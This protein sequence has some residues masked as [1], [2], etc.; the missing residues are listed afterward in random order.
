[1]RTKSICLALAIVL[2][3]PFA[4][5]QWVQTNSPDDRQVPQ[6]PLMGATV[7]QETPRELLGL[8]THHRMPADSLR[9]RRM[10]AT[11][12]EGMFI[13]NSIQ[14]S[15]PSLRRMAFSQSQIYVIDTAI[16]KSNAFSPD[17]TRHLYSFN[18]GAKKTSDFTQRLNGDIWVD[19]KRETYTY[20]A[21]NNMLTDIQEQSSSGQWVKTGYCYIYE[22][23]ANGN[24]LSDLTE[25]WSNNGLLN[26]SGYKFTY[27]ARGNRTFTL[28]EYRGNGQLIHSDRWTYTYDASRNKLSELW[29]HLPQGSSGFTY[30]TT[31]I[32]DTNGHPLSEMR[33]WW[34]NGQWV[35]DYRFT[36]TYDANGNM[37][38]WLGEGWLNGQWVNGWRD[39]YT[40][41]ANSHMLSSLSENW[42]GSQRMS[43]ER[44]TWT[45]DANGNMLSELLENWSNGQWVNN[46]LYTYTYDESGNM[47][48]SLQEGWSNNQWVGLYHFTY[49]YDTNGNRLSQLLETWSDGQWANQSLWTYAYDEETKLT[50]FWSYDWQNSAWT[51][52]TTPGPGGGSI[53]V[54]DNAGNKYIL[55]RCYNFTLSS[56][57]IVTGIASRSETT[58][59]SYALSQNY[60]NPFNPSTTI[61]FQ[62]PRASQV[63]LTVFD[64]VGRDVSV[65]VNDRRD[66][67]VH[68]V[69]FDASGL[70]SGVYF[71]RL[72]A[73]DFT[74][75]KRLLLLR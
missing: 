54:S 24:C 65:L 41:D 61:K 20:D 59:A 46:V 69:R 3:C 15:P 74:Q 58:P 12:P 25:E 33:Q 47:L 13:P 52:L 63:N 19:F 71:C 44:G 40:Y 2:L 31:Y 64:I 35:G 73:G 48:S 36:H 28:H 26:S 14:G 22:Y 70:S 11:L 53:S 68:E 9:A 1:M 27:D 43:S 38:T 67:G 17:T 57:A 6:H 21:S 30:L 50:S 39:T 16:V 37:L 45:Y 60:P 5:A 7:S 34:S 4:S 75:T 32:Y 62:L 51:P 56:R 55:G 72:Q 10:Q 23:D 29:E 66:A 8:S 42:G 49:T 18:T